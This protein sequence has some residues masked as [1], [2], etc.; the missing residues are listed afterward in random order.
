MAS[1]ISSSPRADGRMRSIAPK[2]LWRKK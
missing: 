2:M 1:V